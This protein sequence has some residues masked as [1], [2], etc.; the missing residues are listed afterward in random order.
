MIHFNRLTPPMFLK[1][2]P[3]DQIFMELNSYIAQKPI[4]CQGPVKGTFVEDP[5]LCGCCGAKSLEFPVL[6]G[7]ASAGSR[8]FG[9][10]PS[11]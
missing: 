11:A 2:G 3:N 9:H 4:S 6:G 8:L 1:R 5:A 7:L 10:R